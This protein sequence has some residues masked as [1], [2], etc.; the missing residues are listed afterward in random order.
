[1][2]GREGVRRLGTT[3]NNEKGAEGYP[4]RMYAAIGLS[5]SFHI[6]FPTSMADPHPP[7]THPEVTYSQKVAV[8]AGEKILWS[9]SGKRYTAKHMRNVCK[10]QDRPPFALICQ[11]GSLNFCQSCY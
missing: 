3:W 11:D 6:N 4:P 7:F 9:I 10:E 1:V 2:N 8:V 5:S